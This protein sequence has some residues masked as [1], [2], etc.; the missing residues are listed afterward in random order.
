MKNLNPFRLIGR[1]RCLAAV[2]APLSIAPQLRTRH[3]SE[4]CTSLLHF[5]SGNLASLAAPLFT[6][7]K[8]LNLFW[9]NLDVLVTQKSFL[10][11]HLEGLR[12]FFFHQWAASLPS[13]HLHF[14][15]PVWL[16]SADPI[17]DI[18]QSSTPVFAITVLLFISCCGKPFWQSAV[19]NHLA[20]AFGK[21]E[22]RFHR[23]LSTRIEK[24]TTF[25][26]FL[27]LFHVSCSF[28]HF[29]HSVLKVIHC[30]PSPFLL[31]GLHKANI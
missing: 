29:F 3:Q 31:A 27:L 19:M 15:S 9:L 25:N 7:K 2:H 18:F 8:L 28:F 1:Y 24:T 23:P 13:L 14:C 11:T 10:D 26:S 21:G 17:A 22:L 4:G 20:K 12:F 5:Q 16:S 6:V 30:R